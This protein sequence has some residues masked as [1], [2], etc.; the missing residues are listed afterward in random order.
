[1]RFRFPKWSVLGNILK[2]SITQWHWFISKVYQ[3]CYGGQVFSLGS[4]WAPHEMIDYMDS[5][6]CDCLGKIQRARRW[7]FS[8]RNEPIQFQKRSMLLFWEASYGV[9]VLKR[10]KISFHHIRAGKT[11]VNGKITPACS[12]I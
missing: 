8:A 9:S 4:K 10:P 1:M 3:Q 5:W 11:D 7:N 2:F 12:K 6:F